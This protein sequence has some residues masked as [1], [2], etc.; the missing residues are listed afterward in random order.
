MSKQVS[1]TNQLKGFGF[2][3]DFA[4]NNLTH[5]EFDVG[6]LEAPINTYSANWAHAKISSD[7]RFTLLFGQ[8]I[9]FTNILST[10]LSIDY[11]RERGLNR[12]WLNRNGDF[13]QKLREHV[14]NP[15]SIPELDS[16]ALQRTPPKFHHE[17]STIEVM[18]FREDDADISFYHLSPTEMH[19][20]GLKNKVS[21]NLVRPLVTVVLSS[22]LLLALLEQLGGLSSPTE[23]QESET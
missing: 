14:G 5:I 20:A 19:T 13:Q 10:M 11:G 17:Y 6:K 21:K 9:P 15:L 22:Q 1:T 3:I 16:E 8:I 18:A 4:G 7:G 23:Q 12:P 2:T